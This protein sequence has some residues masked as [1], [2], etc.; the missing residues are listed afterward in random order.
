[1]MGAWSSA[2]PGCIGQDDIGRESWVW[3]ERETLNFKKQS[4][5]ECGGRSPHRE[6]LLVGRKRDDPRMI[7][8]VVVVVVGGY[9]YTSD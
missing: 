3:D 2:T 5:H 9:I 1:M 6:D 7:V 4:P 8:I